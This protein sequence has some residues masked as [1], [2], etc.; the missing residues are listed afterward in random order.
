MHT[1]KAKKVF[2]LKWDTELAIK[3]EKKREHIKHTQEKKKCVW[4]Y[5]A[6]ER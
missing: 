1:K 2:Y 6:E 4:I 3:P 5:K